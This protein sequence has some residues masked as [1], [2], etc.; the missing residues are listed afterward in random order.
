MTR[1]IGAAA[2]PLEL[3]ELIELT[4]GEPPRWYGRESCFA[5]EEQRRAAWQAHRGELGGISG[6][7]RP[8]LLGMV[9]MRRKAER[10]EDRK[11]EILAVAAYGDLEPRELER[12]SGSR[13]KPTPGSATATLSSPTWRP[14]P[15]TGRSARQSGDERAAPTPMLDLRAVRTARSG[16]HLGRPRWAGLRNRRER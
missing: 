12:W 9:A 1:L 4:L 3:E 11:D 16:S 2:R 10:P 15:F 6:H 7:S 8:S 13:S 14:L 5:S